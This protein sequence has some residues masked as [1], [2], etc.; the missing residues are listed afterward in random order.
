MTRHTSNVIEMNEG[1]LVLASHGE[2]VIRVLGARKEVSLTPVRSPGR[3]P[4]PTLTP[5]PTRPTANGAR[6]SPRRR[7]A[8]FTTP[9]C[10]TA[11]SW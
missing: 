11:G 4:T 9:M 8:T 3:R 10:S 6:R 5:K 2:H 1:G 7:S